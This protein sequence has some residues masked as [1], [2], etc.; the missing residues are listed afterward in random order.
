MS[1]QKAITPPNSKESEMITLGCMLSSINSLN[2]GVDNLDDAD[3]YFTEH[4]TIF[5][6]L[7]QSYLQDSQTDVH[8]ISEYLSKHDLLKSVG[9][10]AYIVT[11]A[12]YAGTSAYIE[13][14]VKIVKDKSTLRQMINACRIIEKTAIEEP[15][16]VDDAL[17]DAQN[18]FHKI[19]QSSGKDTGVFLSQIFSGEKAESKLPIMEILDQ[20]RE[21]FKNKSPGDSDITGISTGLIDLDKMINGLNNTNLMILAA[22]PGMGKTA[23]AI[24]IAEH[25]C[26]KLDMPVGIFSLEMEGEQLSH[27]II[28][29]QSR[30]PSENILKGNLTTTEFNRIESAI[31]KIKDCVMTID[32]QGGL[33][34]NE[35]RSR[36]RRMKEAYGIK[37]LV[38]D[39]LQLLS[40]SGSFKGNENRQQEVSEI[41][42]ML[43]NLAKELNIPIL[44]LSQLSRK[45]EERANKQPLMSDLRE[46]GSL[47]QDADI[48]MFIYRREY[49]DK[50]DHP[51]IADLII[52][53]NRH[54]STGTVK[55]VF[56]GEIT[57]FE[58]YTPIEEQQINDLEDR[59]R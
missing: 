44:C 32:D 40:G 10:V 31:D 25:V 34:I 47:E 30:V 59:F 54:G 42:R 14:Y 18:L 58:N 46:S 22:R 5:K 50:T 15:E 17:D 53:K 16:I 26:F 12:Q 4:K 45:V 35:L 37:F 2:Y 20:R 19:G 6:A 8:L 41:S 56:E 24:N 1:D 39:Y 21:K 11:L 7:K 55:L 38:I 43:K 48:V 36:A 23:L 27:R 28:S 3:F 51:G 52:S 29:S 49:Y 9:G 57:K 33:K 13:A